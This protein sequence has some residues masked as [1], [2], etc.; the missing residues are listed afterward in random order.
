[1]LAEKRYVKDGKFILAKG[2][3][4]HTKE[5]FIERKNKTKGEYSKIIYERFE[6][7]I[8][9]LMD[10]E[11]VDMKDDYLLT[12][13]DISFDKPSRTASLVSGKIIGGWGF[14]QGLNKIR[15]NEERQK[16]E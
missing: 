8:T 7:T 2:S 15:E 12:N 14:W 4:I 1:M 10:A 9:Q 5:Y 16:H 13:Q 3:K 11:K 6:K